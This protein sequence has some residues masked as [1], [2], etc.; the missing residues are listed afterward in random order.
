MALRQRTPAPADSTALAAHSRFRVGSCIT[1]S[2]PASSREPSAPP[3]REWA[4][5]WFSR[6]RRLRWRRVDRTHA[7]DGLRRPRLRRWR[8]TD[9]TR[10]GPVCR[11]CVVHL[12]SGGPCGGGGRGAERRPVLGGRPGSGAER[13]RMG[14]GVRDVRAA[15][16]PRPP[17]AHRPGNARRRTGSGGRGAEL[18][19]ADPEPVR[20]RRLP[21]A[22]RAEHPDP[23]R[24]RVDWP[25]RGRPVRHDGAGRQRPRRDGHGPDAGGDLADSIGRGRTVRHPAG[26]PLDAASGSRAPGPA[27]ARGRRGRPERRPVTVGPGRRRHGGRPAGRRRRIDHRHDCLLHPRGEGARRRH[28]RDR[29]AH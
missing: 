6:P 21:R 24:V 16:D 11:A 25:A 18:G 27:G 29:G 10:A 4:A 28:G 19:D 9:E 2:D 5:V 8:I 1:R 12:V 14:G 3:H 26:R 7:P 17:G 13:P 20:G 15:H 23:F 22:R